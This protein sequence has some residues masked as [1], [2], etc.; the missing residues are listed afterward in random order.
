MENKCEKAGLAHAWRES[1]A[2]YGFSM[3]SKEK[4]VNCEL[5]RTKSSQTKEWWYYSDG[6][7]SEEI[8]NTQPV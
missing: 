4:C 6:R 1:S 3:L 2:M 5:E 7:P 8:V